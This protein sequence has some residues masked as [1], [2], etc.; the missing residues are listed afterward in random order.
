M[1]VTRRAQITPH[2]DESAGAFNGARSNGTTRRPECERKAEAQRGSA[3]LER[4]K[5]NESKTTTKPEAGALLPPVTGSAKSG[6]ERRKCEVCGQTFTFHNW[7][8]HKPSKACHVNWK[9]MT[10]Q[11]A[12]SALIWIRVPFAH[13]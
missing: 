1:G 3:S 13:E 6:Q 5:V 12:G 4:I 10:P 7:L 11:P 9:M 2:T 8:W